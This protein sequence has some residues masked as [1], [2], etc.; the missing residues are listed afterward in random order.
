MPRP[1]LWFVASADVSLASSARVRD[2][3]RASDV[4][5]TRTRA[6]ACVSSPSR[7]CASSLA[8][9]GSMTK[10][11]SPR[12][13]TTRLLAPWPRARGGEIRPRKHARRAGERNGR[14]TRWPARAPRPGDARCDLERRLV[15]FRHTKVTITGFFIFT[16]ARSRSS[17]SGVRRPT[18]TAW[19]RSRDDRRWSQYARCSCCAPRPLKVR[20]HS[21]AR[22]ADLT[23]RWA[24]LLFPRAPRLTRPTRRP[25][26]PA[27]QAKS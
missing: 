10:R 8:S 17:A 26:D 11:R 14:P 1:R 2:R 5:S 23:P 25:L 6:H 12:R 9:R 15:F 24:P 21:P 4:S 16:R 27:T 20:A 22:N 18:A 3:P 7:V 13:R 19:A